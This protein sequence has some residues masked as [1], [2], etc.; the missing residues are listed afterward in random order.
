MIFVL[1]FTNDFIKKG[2]FPMLDERHEII[3]FG[4]HIPLKIFIHKL[5]SVTKHWHSSLELLMVLD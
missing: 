4:P 5:G 1:S 2:K 3:E